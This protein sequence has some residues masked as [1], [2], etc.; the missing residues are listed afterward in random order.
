MAKHNE[1]GALGENIACQYLI[2]NG[3]DIVG[4]NINYKVSEIDIIAEKSGVTHFIE[5]KS[6]QKGSFYTTENMTT[7]KQ[8]K[9][10]RA[11]EVHLLKHPKLQ[12]WQIDIAFIS[13]DMNRR[14][15]HVDM[16]WDQVLL[17]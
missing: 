5:V 3:Y 12:K 2:K 15:G 1:I 10:R 17:G 11:I 4:R 14:V 7:H 16:L 6:G 8:R 13:I 9:L